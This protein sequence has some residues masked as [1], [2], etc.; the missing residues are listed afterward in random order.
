MAASSSLK[1]AES[2]PYRTWSDVRQAIEREAFPILDAEWSRFCAFCESEE[3][4][5][6]FDPA[7][8]P[9]ILSRLPDWHSTQSRDS[10]YDGKRSLERESLRGELWEREQPDHSK[11]VIGWRL[12]VFSQ[13]SAR[14]K[15]NEDAADWIRQQHEASPHVVHG[16]DQLAFWQDDLASA[17]GWIE[18]GGNDRLASLAALSHWVSNGVGCSL[19]DATSF[20]L[21]GRAPTVPAL[22]V[23]TVITPG[24][25]EDRE[26][27]IITVNRPFDINEKILWEAFIEQR[28]AILPDGR[29]RGWTEDDSLLV[30]LYLDMRGKKTKDLCRVWNSKFGRSDKLATFSQRLLRAKRKL[31]GEL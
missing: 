19:K 13:R 14:F 5:P 21:V 9:D 2:G 16:I 25:T 12:S 29:M 26:S 8:L 24:D 20:I 1:G 22:H 7:D 27:I 23:R 31:R 30:A 17:S 6:P 10:G 15:S 28:N 11:R 3:L 18:V 4:A